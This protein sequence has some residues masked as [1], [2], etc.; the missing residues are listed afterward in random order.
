LKGTDKDV[1]TIGREL[2]VGHV[3]EGSVRKAGN[4]LRITAQLIDA[5]TD[6]HL[7]AD[8]YSGTMDDVF[9]LQ[10]QVSREIV[11]AL[12]VTLTRDEDRRLA[13]RPIVDP[14][15]FELYIQARQEIRRYGNAVDR[16]M[17]LL[18]QAMDI[19]GETA[20]LQALL[21]L[22]K[23]NQ[24][25]SGTSLGMTP[26]EEAEQIGQHLMASADGAHY[27][28]AVLGMT[29]HTRGNMATAVF[30]FRL[31]LE[32]D[33]TDAD[34][35]FHMGIALN[36]AGQDADAQETGRRFLEHDP[37]GT[38]ALVLA[39]VLPW[40]VGRAADG[41]P[42]LERMLESDPQSVIGRWCLGYAFT[43]LDRWD[44]AA[45]QATWMQLHAEG[46]PYTGQLSAM[47]EAH[48]GNMDVAR[49]WLEGIT[50]L[51]YH[52]KFHV[53]ESFAMVGDT[54]AALT[55]L[56]ESVDSGFTPY[57][58]IVDHCPFLAPLRDHV[59]FAPIAAK[60][61]EA[62]ETFAPGASY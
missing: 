7:W 13:D 19:E 39:G 17:R 58:Y 24:V 23:V 29:A 60:A 10:D 45:S 33:P 59:R 54:E 61:R 16:G 42:Y 4:N 40:F 21:G 2:G 14:R 62:M 20:P 50:G 41:I 37:L 28:H 51:D 22:A 18:A 31:A 12:D 48:R 1:R 57:H 35:W 55:W 44:E 52:H 3:L 47:V 9:D 6:D 25:R 49:G 56:E 46:M 8:K 43:L 27:G 26:L 11:K 5:R 32:H 15:A 38:L 36:A 30:H 53:A 34:L